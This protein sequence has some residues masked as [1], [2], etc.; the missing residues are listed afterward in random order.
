MSILAA[1]TT[2]V[3]A[4]QEQIPLP[5]PAPSHTHTRTSQNRAVLFLGPLSELGTAVV[6]SDYAPRSRLFSV[7][8]P[9]S[10]ELILRYTVMVAPALALLNACPAYLLDGQYMLN[11]LLTWL[12]GFGFGKASDGIAGAVDQGAGNRLVGAASVGG[13]GG[14][15][16]MI[17]SGGDAVALDVSAMGGDAGWGTGNEGM[18]LAEAIFLFVTSLLMVSNVLLAAIQVIVAV[19]DQ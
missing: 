19:Y 11:A 8:W 13:G 18:G 16:G 12:T 10:F 3:I 6:F 9:Q 5:P 14:V 1:N 15:G 17:S 4:H 2:L 7:G